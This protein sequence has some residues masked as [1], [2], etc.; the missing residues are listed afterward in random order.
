MANAIAPSDTV[1]NQAKI[2]PRSPFLFWVIWLVLAALGSYGLLTFLSSGHLATG[3]GS[4]VPWG[5]WIAVYFLG[6][7][8]AGGCF[9]IGAL[10]FIL[11]TPNSQSIREL[12]AAIVTSIAAILPAFLLVWFDLG[13][14]ER[15]F[16][17][18]TNP[19]FTSMMA[20]NAWMYNIFLIIA[21]LAWLLTFV[22]RSVLLKPL[23]VLG[24]ILAIL[25]P[26]Q[27]GVFFEAVATNPFWNSPLLT[28]LFLTSAISLGAAVLLIVRIL[29]G[30]ATLRN[31]VEYAS[32]EAGMRRLRFIAVITLLLYIVFEFAEFS[33]TLWNP[34]R[35]SVSVDFLLFG[36]YWYV[37]WLIHGVLGVI[38]P[39]ILF[40]TKSTAA[41]LTG[42]VLTVIGFLAA[43]LGILIPGQ[44]NEQIP[45][46]QQAFQD[47]RLVY[48]YSITPTE[49]LVVLF[50]LA[51]S[52]IILYIGL[53]LSRYWNVPLKQE[54]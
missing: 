13:R 29:G 34:G 24:S 48:Y 1:I 23:L 26:S 12:R 46:L 16:S 35:H 4:Y 41:W 15:L 9:V 22:D 8:I 19:S 32:L 21:G 17:V 50:A 5:L 42:S 51:C 31:Q 7:G 53:L 20:F 28:L 43:R 54:S 3:Y 52:L 2:K 49:Y 11:A 37:F 10:E 6:V 44:M 14:M 40:S 30:S 36:P 27:S 18:I 33:I 47:Y 39:L 25:F 38:I 45:G